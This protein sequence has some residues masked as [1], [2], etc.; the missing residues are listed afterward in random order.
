MIEKYG[1]DLNEI[2]KILEDKPVIEMNGLKTKESNNR[3]LYDLNNKNSSHL[4]IAVF[5]NNEVQRHGSASNLPIESLVEG[6][7]KMNGELIK[8]VLRGFRDA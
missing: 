5:K 8:E 3:F 4:E 6:F 7:K 2:I 1:T